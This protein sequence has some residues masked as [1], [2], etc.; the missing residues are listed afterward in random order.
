VDHVLTGE[1]PTEVLKTIKLTDDG[2][3]EETVTGEAHCP[4]HL[5]G[6]YISCRCGEEWEGVKAKEKAEKHL[7]REEG[8]RVIKEQ[9]VGTEHR[10]WKLQYDKMSHSLYW[11]YTDNPEIPLKIYATPCS[12]QTTGISIQM[13]NNGGEHLLTKTVAAGQE[14]EE[15]VESYIDI[16][17]RYLDNNWMNKRRRGENQG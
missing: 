14:P 10:G 6:N 16:M 8:T 12:H 13:H 4:D 11:T 3:V 1:F 7:Y 17:T 15:T 2:T 5:T 9:H